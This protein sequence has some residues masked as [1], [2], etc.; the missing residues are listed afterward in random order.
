MR[1]HAL[2]AR[3]EPHQPPEQRAPFP[4]EQRRQRT[5]TAFGGHLAGRHRMEEEPVQDRQPLVRPDAP[6]VVRDVVRRREVHK[7]PELL[8]EVYRYSRR[9][10]G[11]QGVRPPAVDV[12]RLVDVREALREEPDARR[13]LHVLHENAVRLADA[14]LAKELRPVRVEPRVVAERAA[15]APG[16]ADRVQ[17]REH[18][19]LV[20][21]AEV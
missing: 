15:V 20:R 13:A 16:A 8:R 10:L 9:R 2:R 7:R 4:V 6:D 1:G 18:R 5:R 3:R 17:A 14:A 21:R 12:E 11:R 19:L